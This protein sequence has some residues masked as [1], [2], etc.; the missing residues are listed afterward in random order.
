MAFVVGRAGGHP[1]LL[2]ELLRAVARGASRDLP[3][4]V[5]GVVQLVAFVGLQVAGPPGA[6]LAEA[7]LA[8]AAAAL[9]LPALLLVARALPARSEAVLLA[10]RS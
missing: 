3:D 6:L 1:F 7:L 4:T 5:L 10:I 9:S 8:A 2:E